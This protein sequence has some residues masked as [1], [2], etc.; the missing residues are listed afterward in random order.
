MV[1]WTEGIKKE[2]KRVDCQIGRIF[3]GLLIFL[4]FCMLTHQQKHDFWLDIL[5]VGKIDKIASFWLDISDEN[6]GKPSDKNKII[7]HPHLI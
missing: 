5:D 2:K 7:L 1:I 3:L 4:G 6:I